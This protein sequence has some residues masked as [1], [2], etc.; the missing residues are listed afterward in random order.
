MCASSDASRAN[1]TRT[2]GRGIKSGDDFFFKLSPICEKKKKKER[3]NF[4]NCGGNDDYCA[5]EW[6]FFFTVFHRSNFENGDRDELE[7]K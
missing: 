2:S 1:D 7:E 3:N 4:E 6:N 5:E